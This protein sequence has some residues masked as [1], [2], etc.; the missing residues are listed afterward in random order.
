MRS[1]GPGGRGRF[2]P[3]VLSV[4]PSRRAISAL[5]SPSA[6]NS[7]MYQYGHLAALMAMTDSRTVRVV[8]ALRPDDLVDL[9]GHQL[10]QHAEPHS[11]AQRPAALPFAAPASSPS[12]SCTRSGNAS[13]RISAADSS[14]A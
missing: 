7:T 6:A 14:A 10:G 9:L 13:K 3:D 2:T 12:A 11:H 4:H 8:L 5:L 1:L